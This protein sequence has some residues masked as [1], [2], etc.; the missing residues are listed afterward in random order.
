MNDSCL[1]SRN[2]T[3]TITAAVLQRERSILLIDCQLAIHR[4]FEVEPWRATSLRRRGDAGNFNQAVVNS[5]DKILDTNVSNGTAS[6]TRV[7]PEPPRHLS[8]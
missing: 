3:L 2:D 5:Q 6:R 8:E 1:R 4:L 7:M